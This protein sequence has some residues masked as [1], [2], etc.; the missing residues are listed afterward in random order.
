M[1]QMKCEICGSNELKKIEGN[2][3]ECQA[4]SCK[5]T[6]EQAKELLQEISGTVK[7]DGAVKIEGMVTEENLMKRAKDYYSGRNYDK[8][9]EYCNKILDINPRNTEAREMLEKA[10]EKPEVGK[11]YEGTVTRLMQFG[12][13]IEI[14]PGKEGLLHISKMVK[15]K[16]FLS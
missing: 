3:F 15:G 14:L 6:T 7:I 8:T 13:F 2:V 9:I 12:A 11:E 5:Y 10:D 1:M 4:C 16:R